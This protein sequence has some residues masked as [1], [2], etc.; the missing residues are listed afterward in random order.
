VTFT[1]RIG[2]TPHSKLKDGQAVRPKGLPKFLTVFGGLLVGYFVLDFVMRWVLGIHSMS[3]DDPEYYP[4]S[5][6]MILL[7]M[8]IVYGAFGFTVKKLIMK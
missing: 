5:W 7:H 3:Q 2:W 4:N 6:L 1:T 8:V